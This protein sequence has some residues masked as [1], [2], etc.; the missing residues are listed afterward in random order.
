M[1]DSTFDQAESGLDGA[2][3]NGY[4][5]VTSSKGPDELSYSLP[6]SGPTTLAGPLNAHLWIS[7]T[8][9]DT[10]VFVQLIDVDAQGNYQYLQRGMLR[11]SFRALD[12]A[13]SDT[14]ASGPFAGQIYRPYHPFTNPALLTPAQPYE[15]QIEIFPIGHVFRTGHRLL[16]KIHAPPFIDE[17]NAYSSDQPPAVNTILDDPAHPPACSCRCCRRCPRS[18]RRRRRAGLRQGY[19]ASS[20]SRAERRVANDVLVDP[21]W[22]ATHLEDS[23]VA[24]V[25]VDVSPT[26]YDAGHIPGAVLWNAYGDLRQPDYTPIGA[27]EFE[28]LLSPVLRGEDGAFKAA[29][30]LRTLYEEHGVT[31][32][33]GVITYCTI[34]NRAAQ[35]WFVL[36]YLLGYPDVRIYYGSWAEWGTLAEA[37]VAS[38]A[39]GDTS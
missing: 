22:I 3:T 12:P 28:R 1:A 15:L 9:P 39:M 34:G 26:A 4:G 35:A 13:R 33:R 14:I 20:R 6:F 37:P 2:Y 36:T 27:S 8:A 11:A 38:S 7:S 5:R 23:A 18:A 30:H 21:D 24:L 31:P 29:E 19:A 16:V 32:D 25:E 17:L 10:D